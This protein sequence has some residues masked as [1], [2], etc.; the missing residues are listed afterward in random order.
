MYIIVVGGGKVGYYL[1]KTLVNEGYE[2]LLIEKNPKKAAVYS[3][4]FGSVVLEGDGAESS[5]LEAGGIGR[6]DEFP[7]ALRR[8]TR[9][10]RILQPDDLDRLRRRRRRRGFEKRNRGVFLLVRR[11][12]AERGP[13][14]VLDELLELRL[15]RLRVD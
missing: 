3:E 9:R 12:A 5:T 11:R 13:V 2:V 10:D 8:A 6:A 14:D 7:R 4:R 1:T 15:D